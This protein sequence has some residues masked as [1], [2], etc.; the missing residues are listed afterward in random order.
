MKKPVCYACR[1]P[2]FFSEAD[3]PPLHKLING[4]QRLAIRCA[5]CLR[6]FCRK[7]SYK[8]FG[9]SHPKRLR[10]RTPPKTRRLSVD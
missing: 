2:L 8:H 1:C 9:P 5:Y 3:R 10:P 4:K 6:L 7:C